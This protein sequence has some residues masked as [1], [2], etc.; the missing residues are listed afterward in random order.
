[1]AMINTLCAPTSLH[2]AKPRIKLIH[3]IE[4]THNGPSK[5]LRALLKVASS[6]AIAQLQNIAITFGIS[7]LQQFH[8][9]Q[10]HQQ[11]V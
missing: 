9:Q 2:I 10:Q 8:I 3:F 11:C 1:M 7:S 5:P 4:T 6:A